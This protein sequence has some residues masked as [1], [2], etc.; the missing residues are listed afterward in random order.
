MKA[1]VVDMSHDGLG[2]VKNEGVY[3]LEDAI[4]G[5]FVEFQITNEKKKLGK[6][7][8]I[9][10]KSPHRIKSPCPYSKMCG[11]CPLMEMD[12]KRE[13]IWKKDRVKNTIERIGK[14]E[15]KIENTLEN[16]NTFR[17]R[18][19]VQLKVDGNKVGYFKKGTHEVMDIKDCI[20]APVEVKNI[21]EILKNWNGL[22]N[23]DQ[24]TI[25]K[26]YLEE[27]MIILV[28][29]KEIK[30]TN[31]LLNSLL[32]LNVISVYTNI[33]TGKFHYGEEFKE[34]YKKK[35]MYEKIGE[36]L[37]LVNPGSF[38]QINKN[39]VE[40]LYNIGIEGLQ[41]KS[42]ENV[43]DLYS[44]VGTIS[45]KM[46]K[47][48]NQVMG[49]ESFYKSVESAR[50]N[51]VIN[52]IENAEFVA[53][54]VEDL[55]EKLEELKIDKIMLDPPRAGA[56]ES[57]LKAILSLNPKRISYISCNVATLARDLE[58]LKDKYEV[59]KVVPV[60]MFSHTAHVESV[61]ILKRK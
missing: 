15:T 36:N 41:L 54:K 39:Q 29:K 58:I 7:I 26:N 27:L 9:L 51:A 50:E 21:I 5:D 23:L 28:S 24:V 40:N 11:G 34:L 12:Y 61:A 1:K 35:D 49:V 14:I 4:I 13:L 32:D 48:A 6:L 18:N 25:R 3:F 59:E 2:V 53:A 30:N 42:D 60:D 19:V 43:L 46:A 20:V 17:Y 38:F 55:I 45:L 44:G 47:K 16:K 57:V 52:K 33:N 37:F 22:K 10:E 31:T 56:K 8:K